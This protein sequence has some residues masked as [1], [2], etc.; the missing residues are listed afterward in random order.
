MKKQL[1]PR[2]KVL[3]VILVVLM[4]ICAYY[5]AFYVPTTQRVLN[6]ASEMSRVEEQIS[7]V[8]AQVA[9]MNEMKA[10]LDAISSGEMG[11]V[12]ELPAYDNSNNIMQSLSIILQSASQY[13]VDFSSV[14]EEESTVRR[15]I[16][17]SYDCE[18][19]EAAKS[20]LTKIYE[21]EFRSL[22]KDVSISMGGGCHVVV[23]L[24]YYEY[25]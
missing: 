7:L 16:T 23:D 17:L 24:T 9:K 22:I 5:Y 6:L 18:D 4:V 15:H 21:S 11:V 13:T 8:D 10:E 2:E 12:K 20:I 25:K 19:Y 3:L 14:E 1:T